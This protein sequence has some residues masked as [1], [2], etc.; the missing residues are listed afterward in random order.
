[1]KGTTIGTIT[2]IEGNFSLEIPGDA[3]S[4]SFSF[5]GMESQEIIIANQ[6]SFSIKMIEVS[7]GIEEVVAIGYGTVKKSDLTGSLTSVTSAN[8]KDQNVTRVDQVL[9]GRASGVQI[10]NTVGAPGGD[11]R[12]RIRGAN[13][14]LGD[15]SPLVVVDGFVGV[16][17]NMI[18]PNDIKSV[19]ILK[20]AASTSIYG[21]RGANG[22]ILITTKNGNKDGK[23][24]VEYQGEC[25]SF[26]G[27]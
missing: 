25:F 27:G 21:S 18:N 23:I 26:V 14:I 16:D 12:I 11:V 1:M 24:K 13:S 7:V 2:D 10:S 19:E 20:D 3:K 15:N 9:Q 6:T 17:Y 22:V 4:L 8:F 5:V